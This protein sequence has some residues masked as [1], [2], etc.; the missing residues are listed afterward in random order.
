MVRPRICNHHI[1]YSSRLIILLTICSYRLFGRRVMKNRQCSPMNNLWRAVLR[2][3]ALASVTLHRK[4]ASQVVEI[5]A[6]VGPNSVAPHHSRPNPV[7]AHSRPS[8]SQVTV[9]TK[10]FIHILFRA[11]CAEPWMTQRVSKVPKTPV[12]WLAMHGFG[13]M[14]HFEVKV[15]VAPAGFDRRLRGS[16]LAD[17]A[18]CDNYLWTADEK[19]SKNIP[20]HG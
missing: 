19:L 16:A 9:E 14:E 3:R 15:G 17:A 13:G 7:A 12:D 8:P 10:P 20:T 6:P 2:A 1:L 4:P 5:S 11:E 18:W